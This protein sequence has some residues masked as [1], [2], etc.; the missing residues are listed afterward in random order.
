M[1]K[2]G[3]L[4]LCWGGGLEF[5]FSFFISCRLCIIKPSLLVVDMIAD[6]GILFASVFGRVTDA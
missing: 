5:Y 6:I 3:E 2:T 4:G 1:L